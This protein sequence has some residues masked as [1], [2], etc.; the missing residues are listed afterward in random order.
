DNCPA[1]YIAS[2]EMAVLVTEHET[3]RQTCWVEVRIVILEDRYVRVAGTGTSDLQQ[4]LS[5]ARSRYFSISQDWERL[6]IFKHNCLLRKTSLQALPS[7]TGT[8]RPRNTRSTSHLRS[9]CS[10]ADR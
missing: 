2:D 5:G 9:R 1:R 3:W 6:P 7:V 4:D 10:M 8:V